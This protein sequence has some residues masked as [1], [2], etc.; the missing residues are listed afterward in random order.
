[1]EFTEIQERLRVGLEGISFEVQEDIFDPA[2]VVSPGDVHEM[3]RFMRDDEALRMSVLRIVTGIDRPSEEGANGEG[4]IEVVY[5][6]CSHVHGHGVVLKTRL[7]RGD[8]V[9]DSVQD[10]WP[11]ANWHER[12]TYDLMGVRFRGHP[13]LRRIMLPED[14][15]G[16]PLRK[17]YTFPAE[18]HGIPVTREEVERR[19][20]VEEVVPAMHKP[21]REGAPERFIHLNMGPHHPATHGVLNF[22]LETDGEVL[23]RVIPDVG[24]LHRGLEKLAEMTPYPG[25]MPYTDRMDYL[26]AMFTN[27]GFAMACEK[28]FDVEVPRRAEFCRVI[29]SELNRIA[30]HLLAT[31]CLPMEVG[32]FT[33]FVH[34]LREREKVNDFMERICGARLTYNY[35]RIGGVSRDIDQGTIDDIR[36]WLDHLE[37]MIE[38]FDRL[39][40]GNE[41]YV[42]RLADVAVIP[43]EMALG[44]GVVGPN[45]RAS[46]VNWDI[47]KDEP[48]S[49]Y[50]EMEFDVV[51]GQGWRGQLGDAYDRYVCRMLEMN[52][53]IKILR[54]AFDL[55]PEGEVGVKKVPKKPQVNEVYARTEGPRGEAGF[56]IVSDGKDRPY[57][58]RMRTGSFTAISVI[59]EISPGLM[60]ADLV[61]VI[62]SLDTIAPEVDR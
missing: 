18:Y 53:S 27:H 54:Q 4:E 11:T 22:L 26:G 30:S 25:F 47:R 58:L 41:I 37:P 44:Y 17:D 61:A 43:A 10:L 57:R 36:N 56:Y 12:E 7:D 29:A 45:L 60:L 13:D 20:R 34:W 3:C 31:G 55:M 40:S 42:K 1:M 46:G 14:W 48:Y 15:V 49:V 23:K 16:H 52:E 39:I 28:L 8:P 2:V 59:E 32:A 62:G 24:Y 35:M 33:P 51:V 9:V 50:P 5:H 6:L 19:P 38:E 21:K